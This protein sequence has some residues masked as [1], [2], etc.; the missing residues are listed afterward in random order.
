MI[1]IPET[2]PGLQ[3][4]KER[5]TI[6][7]KKVIAM[8]LMLTMVF[9]M[10]ACGDGGTEN[11]TPSE[12]E[13]NTGNES[14]AGD[15]TQKEG[16]G[17]VVTENDMSNMEGS[18]A[19]VGGMAIS[20]TSDKLQWR[21]FCEQLA[22]YGNYNVVDM[23]PAEF[24]QAAQ[25]DK[26]QECIAQKVAA[27]VISPVTDTG[28]EEALQQA[29][30]SG[31]K[32]ISFNGRAPVSVRTTHVN[33]CNPY[34]FAEQNVATSVLQT[35]GVDFD[36]DQ[37]SLVEDAKAAAADY[38][39]TVKIGVIS[40]LP[41]AAI[42]SAWL[43]AIEAA[44]KDYAVDIELDV[45]Y[46]NNDVAQGSVLL[47]SFEM[48]GD[49]KSIICLATN[50]VTTIAEEINQLGSDI[51]LTGCMWA[52]SAVDYTASGLDEDAYD[53]A[54]PWG[55]GWDFEW[56]G[57]VMAATVVA[58]LNGDYTGEIGQTI[59][60]NPTATYPEGAEITTVES[61]RDTETGGSEIFAQDPVMYYAGNI[62]EWVDQENS[63][64]K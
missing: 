19:W 26:I 6:M 58:T 33:Q 52:S 60:V 53:Y 43:R 27:I 22:T 48:Q 5:Y 40:T 49:I 51:K 13:K 62:N 64:A 45:K 34:T 61:S 37:D 9:S 38:G 1:V 28:V 15:D 16:T 2:V 41:D 25:I 24:T 36:Y 17:Y 10:A 4:K 44:A 23:G 54:I 21:G 39:Q 7:M 35:L 50:T 3:N 14:N 63:V 42:Q 30:N 11:K 47:N 59:T 18:I 31:I 46:T 32:V 8:L 20:S 56:W 29:I 57:E 55:F 12:S